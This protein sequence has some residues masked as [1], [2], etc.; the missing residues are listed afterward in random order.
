MY[1]LSAIKLTTQIH[2]YT[3]Q[4]KSIDIF[5]SESINPLL[6]IRCTGGTEQCFESCF[7]SK[8][9][10]FIGD[11]MLCALNIYDC[12]SVD[13]VRQKLRSFADG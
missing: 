13:I 1:Q 5:M 7:K 2:A 10:S 4:I 8:W 3:Y 6:L 9:R 12:A 11:D